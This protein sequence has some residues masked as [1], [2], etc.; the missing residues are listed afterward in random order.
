MVWAPDYATPEE[1]KSYLRVGDNADDVFVALWITTVSRNIDDHCG[2]QFGQTASLEERLY[3][4]HYN[5][6]DRAYTVEIDDVQDVTGLTVVDDSN[7][8]LTDY[9][10]LPKNAP[11]KGKPYERI[12][13]AIDPG[14]VAIS[15]RWGWTAVPS[16]VKVG[17][18][19]QG[20][21]L[22]ARR[23]SPFGI[24]G[25][26][27]EGSEIRLLAQLDPDFRTSLRPFTRDWW[28]A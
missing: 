19:L 21:R 4:P 23:D 2:R 25:S 20:A 28:A 27:S 8:T 14:E 1:L 12:Q 17:L 24:A 16:A 5:R 11:Q 9:T 13:F 3:T 10:L 26:P 15:A 18:L 22:A 6:F 7:T